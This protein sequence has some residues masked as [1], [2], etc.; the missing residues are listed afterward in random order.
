[1][2]FTPPRGGSAG[3]QT[4]FTQVTPD[5]DDFQAAVD[6]AEMRFV[7]FGFQGI[8]AGPVL[9][10][11]RARANATTSAALSTRRMSFSFRGDR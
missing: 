3:R 6:F 11:V 8:S 7:G 5:E 9:H 1:M 10:P 2:D 4:P